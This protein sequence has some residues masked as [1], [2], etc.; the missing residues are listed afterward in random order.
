MAVT[1]LLS[2]TYNSVNVQIARKAS[3]TYYPTLHL[4]IARYVALAGQARYELPWM[5]SRLIGSP[6]SA[7]AR[8][9]KATAH[10][11]QPAGPVPALPSP[12]RTEPL[13][14]D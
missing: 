3:T 14:I 6:P 10:A 1:I 9:A 5:L 8:T 11:S 13:R 4:E 2:K 12:R 7:M